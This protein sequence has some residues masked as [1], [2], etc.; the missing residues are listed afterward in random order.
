MTKDEAKSALQAGGSLL[1]ARASMGSRAFAKVN[2]EPVRLDTA[3]RLMKELGLTPDKPYGI[4][5]TYRMPSAQP[6]EAGEEQD[7]QPSA[8]SSGPSL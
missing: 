6:T 5:K 1:Y 8:R 4:V 2:G 7:E 3:H